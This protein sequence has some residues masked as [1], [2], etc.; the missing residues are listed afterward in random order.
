MDQYPDA[1]PQAATCYR[2][3]AAEARR[4]AA[5]VTTRAI[6][7][8]LHDLA[9]EFGRLANAADG[10]VQ[11]RHARQFIGGDDEATRQ[12]LALEHWGERRYRLLLSVVQ[13]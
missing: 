9:R 12:T 11:Q 1:P 10:A 13:E 5:E 8:R 2:Q 4:A 3:K 7:G 6:K